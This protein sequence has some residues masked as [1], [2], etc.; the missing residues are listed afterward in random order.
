MNIRPLKHSDYKAIKRIYQEGIDTQLA[1]FE[2]KVPDWKNWDDK[3]FPFCRFVIDLDG[4]IGG[5]AALSPVSKRIVYR[6][7]AEVSIYIAEHFRGKGFGKVLLL[8][9][10]QEAEKNGICCNFTS[11][12]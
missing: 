4:Q 11:P 3:N 6:G 5:W 2:T 10:I 12:P 9:L 1:T 8:H 7:V